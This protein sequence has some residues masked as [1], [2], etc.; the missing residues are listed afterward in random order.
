MDWGPTL[1]GVSGEIGESSI[2]RIATEQKSAIFQRFDP[3]WGFPRIG[4][5]LDEIDHG[6]I[7]CSMY[8]SGQVEYIYLHCKRYIS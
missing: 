3:E 5:P 8:E 6:D 7:Q 2:S 1:P 4:T